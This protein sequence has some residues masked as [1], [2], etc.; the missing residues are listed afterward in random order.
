VRDPFSAEADPSRD[1]A[2]RLGRRTLV[3]ALAVLPAAA[4]ACTH[5]HPAC[6]TAPEDAE[7]CRHRFCRY[8]GG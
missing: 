7:H 2:P 1:E 5:P 8:H 3:V 6:P 4:S